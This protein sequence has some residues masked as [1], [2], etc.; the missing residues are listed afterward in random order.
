MPFQTPLFD[1]VL[2]PYKGQPGVI[3]LDLSFVT[4]RF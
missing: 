3:H 2:L 4:P 1:R